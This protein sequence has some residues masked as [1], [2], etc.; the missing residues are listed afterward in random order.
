MTGK[1]SIFNYRLLLLLISI[2]TLINSIYINNPY[3]FIL[4]IFSLITCTVSTKYGIKFIKKYNLLQTIRAEGPT[5]H[6]I[7]NKTPTMGGLFIIPFF[8]LI[9][10][11]A[12]IG[13]LLNPPVM[14]EGVDN[15]A[16]LFAQRQRW[17][18]GGL[19]R[20]LDY[21]KQ[22]IFGNI[23][24]SQKFDIVYFFI[25]QYAL[26]IITL[27]DL[28][29]SIS[30]LKKPVYWPISFTAFMLSGIASW[31]GCNCK[32]EG[33]NLPKSTFVNLIIYL[34]YLSH[35]FVVIPFVTLKMS[36]LP[37]KILWKK[38]IHKGFN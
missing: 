35:W 31:Y 28:V 9:L 15:I 3:I 19:Q 12:N 22:L 29:V 13:I 33:P 24:F 2:I 38:T 8:F 14:E 4:Y 34:F 27:L 23:N 32:N 37:K 16:A 36:L 6:S 25:L 30:L 26:P 11:G 1:S 7:K 21:W 17:A 20:F 5:S 18:E 10:S